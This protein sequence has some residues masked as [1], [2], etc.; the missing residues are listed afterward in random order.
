MVGTY[1]SKTA[2]MI[3]ET[4]GAGADESAA[5]AVCWAAAAIVA[6]A[7][8]AV[9]AD[10]AGWGRD[11]SSN[12]LTEVGLFARDRD[13]EGAADATGLPKRTVN[14]AAAVAVVEPLREPK[15]PPPPLRYRAAGAAGASAR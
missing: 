5:V 15:G 10:G 2:G 13:R 8:G 1:V 9:G 12:Q 6:V 14:A 7:A 11:D 4:G 3:I